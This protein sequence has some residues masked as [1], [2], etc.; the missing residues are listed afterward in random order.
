MSINMVA[1]TIT[2]HSLSCHMHIA[3]TYHIKLVPG[4]VV[5]GTDPGRSFLTHCLHFLPPAL[6]LP[7]STTTHRWKLLLA[8]KSA[9]VRV[10]GTKKGWSKVKRSIRR[11]E[12]IFRYGVSRR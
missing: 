12:E 8:T 3:H 9:L 11:G 10:D 1:L 7:L 2:S 6:V 5:I 4:A